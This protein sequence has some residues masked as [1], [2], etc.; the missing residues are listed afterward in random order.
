MKAARSVP[1][2]FSILLA[3]APAGCGRAGTPATPS[4]PDAAAAE[5]ARIRSAKWNVRVDVQIVTL[6]EARALELLPDLRS[7]DAQKT[8]AAVAKL[9]EMIG[10]KEA[11]LIGWP[12]VACLDGVRAVSEAIDEKRYPTDFTT[13]PPAEPQSPAPDK[14]AAADKPAGELVDGEQ[15]PNP[16]AFETRNIGVSLEVEPTVLDEGRR[17]VISVVPQRVALKGFI[18]FDGGRDANGHPLTIEQPEFATTKTTTTVSIR[19]GQHVLLNFHKSD[20]ESEIA[21]LV[22]LHAVATKVD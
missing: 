2:L 17:L 13:P 8:A 15:S 11:T 14:P 19:N 9:Q 6:P 20:P 21:E 1:A 4:A 7:D 5:Q 18:T 10:S 12:E 3:V 16:A 22:I